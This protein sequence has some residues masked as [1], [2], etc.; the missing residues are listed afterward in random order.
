MK[1]IINVAV[2]ATLGLCLSSGSSAAAT[3][4]ATTTTTTERKAFKVVKEVASSRSTAYRADRKSR[5]E[6]HRDDHLRVVL[7]DGVRSSSVSGSSG[8]VGGVV[9]HMT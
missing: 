8:Y 6:S 4:T 2:V 9:D 5:G 7:R 3:A 1:V